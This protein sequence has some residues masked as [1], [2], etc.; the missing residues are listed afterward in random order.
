[1]KIKTINQRIGDKYYDLRVDYLKKSKLFSV[2]GNLPADFEHCSG[3]KEAY[4]KTENE[5]INS[6]IELIKEYEKNKTL[7]RKVILYSASFS[8]ILSMNPIGPGNFSGYLSKEMDKVCRRQRNNTYDQVG[9]GFR[10]IVAQEV[11]IAGKKEYT[12]YELNDDNI[13]YSENLRRFRT[14]ID[15]EFTRVIEYS[16]EAADFFESMVKAFQVMAQKMAVFFA[17][18]DEQRIVE[19]IS[20]NQNLLK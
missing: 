14:S 11:D 10:Y 15:T 9:I 19:L 12:Q 6:M 7:S 18:T 3:A 17:E 13:T 8:T 20:K 2:S 5:A 1:M 16:K 4:G